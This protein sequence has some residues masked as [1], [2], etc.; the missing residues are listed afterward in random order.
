M[1]T[2]GDV[3]R[4]FRESLGKSAIVFGGLAGWSKESQY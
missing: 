1:K 2:T 4:E 3:L